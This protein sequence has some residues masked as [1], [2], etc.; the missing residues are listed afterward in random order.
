MVFLVILAYLI[1]GVIEI[2]PLLKK[3]QKK[4]LVLYSI[5]FI[6]A[7]VISILLS[8]GVKIPSPAKAIEKVVLTVLGK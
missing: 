1:I 8:L 4:E 6:L 5:T 7:F 2:V 3:N